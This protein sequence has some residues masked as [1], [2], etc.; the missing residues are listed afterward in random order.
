MEAVYHEVTDGRNFG[1]LLA[2]CVGAVLLAGAWP[3][4]SPLL[5]VWSK[6]EYSHAWFILPLGSFVFLDRL[7]GVSPRGSR[8][9]GIAIVAFSLGLA[10]FGWATGSYTAA[11]YAALTG[12]IGF[13]WASFGTQSMKRLAAPLL[14]LFFMVPV[15]VALYISISADMQLLSSKLGM[16]L[17][18]LSGISGFLDGNIIVLPSARLEVA[19]ACSGLR[20]LF[21]LIS[22]AYFL[23]MMI[24][25]RFWKKAI[26]LFSSIPIAIIL[27][28]IRIA[29]IAIL[30]EQLGIDTTGG[31][32]H[33]LEGF[34]VFLMCLIVLFLEVRTLFRLGPHRG[35]FV[36]ISTSGLV[37]GIHQLFSWPAHGASLVA[38]MLLVLGTLSLAAI[39]ARS[40]IIPERSPFVIFPMQLAGWRG[41]AKPLDREF[42]N[43]LGATDYLLADYTSSEGDTAPLNFYIAY[44][45]SQRAGVHAH[46][47]QLCIP[48]GGWNIINH[49]IVP[50]P[51]GEDRSIRVN[52]IVIE[53][54]GIRQIVYYWFEERGRQIAEEFRLKYYAL[55][56]M[57]LDDR[58]DGALVRIVAPIDGSGE[59]AADLKAAQLIAQ[60]TSV[61]PAFVPGRMP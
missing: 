37:R 26:L 35:R 30:L 8:G 11:L 5:A 25:D 47:P 15:P 42:Q 40:E 60:T 43:A 55:R 32:S 6:E 51:L 34:A 18:S 45:A 41:A 57:L 27:N 22:F 12:L 38:G 1:G 44:Y 3:S 7:R 53:K 29:M 2:L 16:A 23:S 39:P 21:P 59:H 31:T 52:R 36:S 24:E 48:G 33:A 14:Y 13:V 49:S 9:P 10:A 58:T 28:A 19:E 17:I 4:L 54:Q 46:S 20:Y 61:L 56:D 50:V